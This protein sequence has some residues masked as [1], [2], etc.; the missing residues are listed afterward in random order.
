[1][2]YKYMELNTPQYTI[3]RRILM[4][5]REKRQLLQDA[6]S[7]SDEN[8][9]H[10]STRYSM[11][12][13]HIA[14]KCNGL[15]MTNDCKNPMSSIYF[16]GTL[17]KH[18]LKEHNNWISSC[19]KHKTNTLGSSKNVI[20]NPSSRQTPIFSREKPSIA[21]TGDLEFCHFHKKVSHE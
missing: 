19:R 14:G 1:M 11:L 6:F 9:I 13:Q 2:A 5:R 3:K 12:Y 8:A 21:S 17:G 16:N 15:C 7:T 20:I 18:D 4:N 10:L